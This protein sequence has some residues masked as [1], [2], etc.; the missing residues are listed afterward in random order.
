M[1]ISSR[2]KV[3]RLIIPT[4][5]VLPLTDLPGVGVEVAG[6]GV[7]GDELQDEAGARRFGPG[8]GVEIA[9]GDS[10]PRSVART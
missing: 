7:G 6:Q 2:V 8:V 3:R 9:E 10:G 5:T 1:G 4:E